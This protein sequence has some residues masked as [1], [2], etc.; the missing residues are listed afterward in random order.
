MSAF[1]FIACE[2][3]VSADAQRE[4]LKH[5]PKQTGMGPNPRSQ[6]QALE[7]LGKPGEHTG[8]PPP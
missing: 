6:K 4:D 2:K 3:A 5:Q 1:D 7:I 8:S